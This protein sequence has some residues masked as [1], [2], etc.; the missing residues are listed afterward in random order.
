[1]DYNKNINDV[2]MRSMQL[3]ALLQDTLETLIPD[4]IAVYDDSFEPRAFGDNV[5]KWGTSSI[6]IESGGYPNDPE[7]QYLRELNFLTLIKALES[8][9]TQSYQTETV[10]AYEAIPENERRMMSLIIKEMQVPVGQQMV[11]MDVGYLY[12]ERMKNN[13][14]YYPAS[15]VDVGDLSIYS[16][17]QE[18]S[19]EKLEVKAGKWYPKAF[20]NL[21]SLAAANWPDMIRNGY[22]G[23]KVSSGEVDHSPETNFIIYKNPETEDS[24]LELSIA[25]G[26]DPTF[27]LL[28]PITGQ[29]WIVHNG[30]VYSEDEYIDQL[31]K[32]F[33]SSP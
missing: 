31:R 15:I 4:R 9:L 12:N 16:G 27:F 26:N 11:R 22:L 21:K 7:K 24:R 29:R 18:F 5:M 30:T 8:I 20:K 2:R 1:Y 28:E 6:L 13:Q 25:P 32:A 33:L 10:Q 23:F 14:I 3:I 17:F 19:A